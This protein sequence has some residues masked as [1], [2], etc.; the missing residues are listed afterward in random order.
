M[1]ASL[2]ARRA[3]QTGQFFWYDVMTTDVA[4]AA[5]FYGAV[6]GWGTQD[7]PNGYTLF[8]VKAPDGTDRGVAGLMAIPPH[9]QGM[10]PCWMGY[11]WADDVDAVCAKL[12]DLGG[13]VHRGPMDVEGIIRFAVVGDPQGAGFLIAKGMS[14]DSQAPL[15]LNTPGD[16]GW[17]E[18]YAGEWQAAFAFYEKLFGWTKA[19]AVDMGP[20]GTYQLFKTGGEYAAGG[21]MTKPPQVPMPNWGYYINVDAAGAAA[22]RVKAAGGQ[23][24]NGPMEVPG[25]MW[26]VQALDPLGAYFAMVS[27]KQ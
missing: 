7:A 13:T 12:Q 8:T 9:A 3:M 15:A 5:K 14:P 10:P 19:D 2:E 16:I 18:L 27:S 26:I 24:L 17:R 11:V 1:H 22:E 25:P 6:I 20:M 21:M 4:A 23:V